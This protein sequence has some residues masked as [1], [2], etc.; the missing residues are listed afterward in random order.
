MLQIGGCGR[1][2]SMLTKHNRFANHFPIDSAK[3]RG[4]PPMEWG[5]GRFCPISMILAK[6]GIFGKIPKIGLSLNMLACR[7]KEHPFLHGA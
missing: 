4:P 1:F 5:Y 3:N 7:I 2:E 6:N